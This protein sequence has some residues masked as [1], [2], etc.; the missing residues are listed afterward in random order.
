MKHKNKKKRLCVITTTRAEFGLLKNLILELKKSKKFRV[1]LIASGS[2]FIRKFGNTRSE[3]DKNK[4]KI[5]KRIK[6]N[7]KNDKKFDINNLNIKFSSSLNDI[8]NKTNFDGL[9]LLGDRSEIACAALI[10]K[11][12]N[13]PIFHIHGGEETKGVTDNY[14]RKV[15]SQLSTL[16]F[17]AHEEYKKN[18]IKM[19][20]GKRKIF[21]VG[22]LGASRISKMRFFTK[23]ELSRILKINFSKDT[24][25]VTYHPETLNLKNLVKDFNN[26]INGLNYFKN[27]NII[28]TSPNLDPGH[29]LIIK[30]IKKFCKKRNKN[31]FYIKSIGE[32]LYYNVL[33][34]SKLVIGNSSSA[35]LEAPSFKIGI[36]NIGNRQKGRVQ[37]NSIINC[38]AKKKLI[39]RS[40]NKILKDKKFSK[41]LTKMKNPLSR[42]NTEK[43]LC[44]TIKNYFNGKMEKH[45]NY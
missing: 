15:I 37:A 1:D 10:A 29:N 21:L 24:I 26:L 32:N 6:L 12:Y 18:L 11:T 31:S 20:I 8:F 34:C 17:V 7:Y 4:I 27:K 2:H 16:H 44:S 43:N 22:G 28:F 39:I 13:I 36:I 30:K 45:L 40:I 42:K 38:R 33:N 35:I 5:F 25:V 41:K 19:N 23:L 14:Y 9:I 3:I